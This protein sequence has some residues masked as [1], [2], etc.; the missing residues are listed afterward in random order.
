[1]S[2][3]T[4]TAL[5]DFAE[6]QISAAADGEPLENVALITKYQSVSLKGSNKFLKISIADWFETEGRGDE[7][8]EHDCLFYIEAFV[9]PA[10]ET[11]SD[12]DSAIDTAIEIMQAIQ[13]ALLAN[14]DLSGAVCNLLAD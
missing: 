5:L 10:S 2:L 12:E 4:K 13:R 9:R 7:M 1:M 11:F 3:Y 8:V 6:A 14:T